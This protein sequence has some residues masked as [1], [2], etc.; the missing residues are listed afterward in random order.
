MDKKYG[1]RTTKGYRNN[2]GWFF[3]FS[4]NFQFQVLECFER[5]DPIFFLKILFSFLKNLGTISKI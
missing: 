3:S 5:Y 1:A 4:K 2:V